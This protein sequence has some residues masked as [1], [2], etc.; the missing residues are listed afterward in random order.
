M[1]DVYSTGRLPV[2]QFKALAG[3]QVERTSEN[4]LHLDWNAGKGR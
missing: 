3:V 1:L 2:S 4:S